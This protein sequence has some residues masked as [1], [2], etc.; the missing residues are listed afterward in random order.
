M[1]RPS[2][3]RQRLDLM[4]RT[5]EQANLLTDCDETDLECGRGRASNNEASALDPT[6]LRNRACAPGL[7]EAHD[8]VG[9]DRAIVEHAPNIRMSVFP[10]KAIEDRV[11]RS[12]P[13]GVIHARRMPVQIASVHAEVPIGAP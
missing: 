12:S 13:T 2:I 8:D 10:S 6:H 11:T 7:D 1:P 5:G 3:V 4:L 9:E